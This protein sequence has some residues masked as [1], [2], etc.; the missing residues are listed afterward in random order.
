[1]NEAEISRLSL[2]ALPLVAAAFSPVITA[3][4]KRVTEKAGGRI[5]DPLKPALNVLFGV[6]IAALTGGTGAEGVVGAVAGNKVRD[7]TVGL[8]GVSRPPRV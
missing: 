1:M 5:P 3:A 6:I 2:E 7:A 8:R 4:T